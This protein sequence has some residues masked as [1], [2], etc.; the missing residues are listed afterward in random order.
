MPYVE[1]D[2]PIGTAAGIAR[3]YRE[4]FGARTSLDDNSKARAAH[5]G[6]GYKQELAFR[7]TAR[8]RPDF[9]GHHIQIY[10]QDFSTPYQGL[11]KQRLITEESSPYQYRFDEIVD[12]DTGKHLFALEHEVRSMTHPLFARVLVNRNPAQSLG[13]YQMGADEWEW[14]LPRSNAPLPGMPPIVPARAS[15]LAQRRRPPHGPGSRLITNN[16]DAA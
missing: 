13:Y 11:E 2:V 12:L 7:E 5:I 4:I 15:A 8:D 9:D 16:A 6:V 14:E 3:F 10:V 1:F